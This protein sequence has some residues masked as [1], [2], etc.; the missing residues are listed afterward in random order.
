MPKYSVNKPPVEAP[1]LAIILQV[2]PVNVNAF[3]KYASVV[4]SIGTK[5]LRQG[6][7]IA[8]MVI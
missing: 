5:A 8:A 3:F 4:M 1:T 7:Y 6:S 2:K